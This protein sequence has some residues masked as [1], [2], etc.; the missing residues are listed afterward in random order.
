MIVKALNTLNQ[1]RMK[2][3]LFLLI[4]FPY[5]AIAQDDFDMSAFEEAS[6]AKVYVNNKVLGLSPTKLINISYD[7]ATQNDWTTSAGEAFIGNYNS[8]ENTFARNH[9]LRIETNYPIISNNRLIVNAYLNYWESRLNVG[10]SQP[11]GGNFREPAPLLDQN[12]LRT[13]ALGAFVF[14]PLNDKNFLLF[15]IE[16]ALNGNYNFGSIDS[17]FDKTKFSAAALYGWK[18]D[19]Y[20]NFAVG[21]SRTYRGGR[22]LYIPAVLYNKTFNEKWG[23]E[24]L[25][26]ARAAVRRNF[27]TKSFL[28]LGYELE[29]QSYHLQGENG[30]NVSNALDFNGTNDAWELRKSEIRARISWDKSITDFI[31]FNV[32][33]GALITYRMDFDFNAS[34]S[35]AWL[36]ND[37]GI[38]F[39]LRFGIQLV[40]P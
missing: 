33:A 24:M 21:L 14:K 23:L 26:P 3:Y 36:T 10:G 4:I 30:G 22:L 5:V 40:S 9:G 17:E 7:F 37:L 13:T 12:E 11:L 6:D 34:A 8:V 15:Q 25:L 35:D 1:L 29:G 2:K 27:S 18:T 32:Q 38:P 20:T 28:M 16:G 31:W 39:Y 19:D